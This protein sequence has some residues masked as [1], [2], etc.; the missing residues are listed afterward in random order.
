[1]KRLRP[2]PAA[3]RAPSTLRIEQQRRDASEGVHRPI[4]CGAALPPFSEKH[5]WLARPKRS[6]WAFQASASVWAATA[7]CEL[8]AGD[9]RL[10][11]DL[12]VTGFELRVRRTAA[13]ISQHRKR[14]R[15][16]PGRDS[17]PST[18]SPRGATPASAF[19]PSKLR[20]ARWKHKRL[21]QQGPPQPPRA[22]RT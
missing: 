18:A 20:R 22:Q 1:M 3:Y 15:D 19:Q 16:A 17:V 10:A 12:R 7:R 5:V 4:T 6:I 9:W 13:V 11:V 21:L 8:C 2:L 14:Q